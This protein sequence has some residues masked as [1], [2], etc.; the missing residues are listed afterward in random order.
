MNHY[1]KLP[2]F[3]VILVP[4][5]AFGAAQEYPS[6]SG[7]WYPGSY[8]KQSLNLSDVQDAVDRAN[9]ADDFRNGDIVH[10]KAGTVEWGGTLKINKGI[11]LQGAGKDK[12]HIIKPYKTDSPFIRFETA[13]GFRLTGMHLRQTY[14][15]P[16][17]QN[18]ISKGSKG[19][20]VDHI[21]IEHDSSST[22]DSVRGF[23]IFTSE[24]DGRP[25][26]VFD[27]NEFKNS[28]VMASGK[29]LSCANSWFSEPSKLGTVD[30]IYFEDN[31]TWRTGG[32]RNFIDSENGQSYVARYN[33]II[34]AYALVHPAR[35]RS[36]NCPRRGGRYWEIYEN[37]F[38]HPGDWW[39]RAINLE[40]GT[41]VVFNNS[42]SGNFTK[43][44][45]L[46]I[47]SRREGACGKGSKA[48]GNLGGNFPGGYWCRDGIGRATDAF[49]WE[50]EGGPIPEQ[51]L[52]PAYFW[53]NTYKVGINMAED[54]PYIVQSRDYYEDDDNNM[55][56]GLWADRPASCK[57]NAGYWA[58][59]KGGDWN[60]INNKS[61]DGALYICKNNMWEFYYKPYTYPH[62][63]RNASQSKS[64][65]QTEGTPPGK[66]EKTWIEN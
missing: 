27:N 51:A 34:G 28:S 17:Y 57:N 56:K 30:A 26:G 2:I 44:I 65:D 9:G 36:L 10:L 40:A 62:P 45:Q 47:Y 16:K 33:E 13:Q 52:E 8:S 29:S 12:T 66:V 53:N 59:D 42:M 58:T 43:N 35:N 20:R 32:S 46:N 63:L 50:N 21:F 60:K 11:T 18:Y 4:T 31:K 3:I 54:K 14:K 22:G 15:L 25:Y 5:I 38:S 55:K 24:S 49:E 23:V 64:A 41:G 61:N 6:G 1:L 39:Q 7:N 19:F 48:D 37:N